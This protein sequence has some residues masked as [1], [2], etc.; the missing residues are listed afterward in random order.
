MITTDTTTSTAKGDAGVQASAAKCISRMT[1]IKCRD[2]DGVGAVQSNRLVNR[3]LHG[4]VIDQ[5][6]A[7]EQY[8][9][10]D[11][12]LL[13]GTETLN[14]LDDV[15]TAAIIFCAAWDLL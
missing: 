5:I 7:D 6:L 9:S 10:G 1:C 8:A 4:A 15:H 12:P 3:Y 13:S 2:S 14:S 11:G